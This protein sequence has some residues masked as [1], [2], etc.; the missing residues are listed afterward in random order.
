MKKKPKIASKLIGKPA[1]VVVVIG[2][3]SIK[4]KG[5]L[6]EL[7]DWVSIETKDGI[8]LINKSNCALIEEAKP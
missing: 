8:K 7:G 5:I 6:K 4:Y 1:K 3:I 2:N